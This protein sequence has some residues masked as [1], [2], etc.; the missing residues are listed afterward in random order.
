MSLCPESDYR[1][2]LGDEDFWVYVLP[3]SG[4]VEDPPDAAEVG[5]YEPCPECGERGAC[6]Y[7]SLGRAMVHVATEEDL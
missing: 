3:Y 2:S 7:D 4:D 5:Q 1:A 6:G